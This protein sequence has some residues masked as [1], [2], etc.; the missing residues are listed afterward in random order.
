MAMNQTKGGAKKRNG[1]EMNSL[2]QG[3]SSNFW[4]ESIRNLAASKKISTRE[5]A[6]LLMEAI[7]RRAAQIEQQEIVEYDPNDSP[8]HPMHGWGAADGHRQ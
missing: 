7:K 1:A 6:K 4:V 8:D 3:D 2:N 5:S